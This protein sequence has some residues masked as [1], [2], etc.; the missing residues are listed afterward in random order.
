MIL[1][2]VSTELQN[3]IEECCDGYRSQE[4]PLIIFPY[5]AIQL[6]LLSFFPCSDYV[7]KPLVV[8]AFFFLEQRLLKI[9]VLVC[10]LY[11]LISYD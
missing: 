1:S 4:H 5:L 10:H 11:H 2:E 6:S 7:E 3:C 8:V 9:V